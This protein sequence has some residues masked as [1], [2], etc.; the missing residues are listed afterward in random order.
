VSPGDL[1]TITALG[2]HGN[3]GNGDGRY[4][5]FN[6]RGELQFWAQFES[7]E[8]VFISE[9]V[10]SDPSPADFNGDGAVDGSDL[11]AWKTGFGS[12]IEVTPLDGDAN[13]DSIIDGAD[14][15]AWQQQLGGG[16]ASAALAGVALPAPEPAASSML[17]VG[18]LATLI[19]RCRAN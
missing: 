1:R 19:G 6:D 7:S 5:M 4:S 18:M 16:A 14:F 8:G 12:T 15:L 11:A 2:F 17:L 13:G 10:E 9:L 3:S